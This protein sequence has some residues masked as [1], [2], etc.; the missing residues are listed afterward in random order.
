MSGLLHL[1]L[2]ARELP[3]RKRQRE[4][5]PSLKVEPLESC[6]KVVVEVLRMGR[7]EKKRASDRC[8]GR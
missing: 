7:L 2:S 4:T 8:S 5:D 1:V 3:G 6:S